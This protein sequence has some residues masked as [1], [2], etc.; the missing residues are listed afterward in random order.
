MAVFIKPS[1]FGLMLLP[2][3]LVWQSGQHRKGKRLRA[4]MKKLDKEFDARRDD[5][6]VRLAPTPHQF[7]RRLIS[8]CSDCVLKVNVGLES[9]GDKP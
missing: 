5:G 8:N 7:A 2:Q 4:A 6:G 3:V 1:L 9:T